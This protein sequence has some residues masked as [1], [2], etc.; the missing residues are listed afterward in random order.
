M[1]EATEIAQCR[2][3]SSVNLQCKYISPRESSEEINA[4]CDLDFLLRSL[5]TSSTY[6]M[7]D[8]EVLQ[9]HKTL[10]KNMIII[11]QYIITV[12]YFDVGTSKISSKF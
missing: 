2:I 3:Q 10:I 6:E 1:D 8:M 4:S 5:D 12:I 7:N 9:V 11:L